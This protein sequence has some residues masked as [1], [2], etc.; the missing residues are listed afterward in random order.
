[1]SYRKILN[2][3]NATGVRRR[4]RSFLWSFEQFA[5]VFWAAYFLLFGARKLLWK[6]IGL[7]E[8]EMKSNDKCQRIGSE[9]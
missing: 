6:L 7:G 1:M 3:I 8:R 5:P 9:K 2:M 4:G